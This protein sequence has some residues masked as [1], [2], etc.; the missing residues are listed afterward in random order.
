MDASRLQEKIRRLLALSKSHNPHEA[1]AAAAKAQELMRQQS[2]QL[3]SDVRPETPVENLQFVEK[4]P[5]F[6][7]HEKD[8]WGSSLALIFQRFQPGVRVF[9]VPYKLITKNDP[10]VSYLVV[11]PENLAVTVCELISYVGQLMM[12][13][14]EITFTEY[15]T[16]L[17]FTLHVTPEEFKMQFRLG[18]VEGLRNQVE[19]LQT[20]F[21]QEESTALT[22]ID[23][24]LEQFCKQYDTVNASVQRHALASVEKAGFA[25]GFLAGSRVSLTAQ[26]DEETATL[27]KIYHTL[28]EF[29]EHLPPTQETEEMKNIRKF[30]GI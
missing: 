19:C 13:L 21:T 28:T 3:F 24:K 26:I 4:I 17:G 12:D 9:I 2:A 29:T 20:P 1:A 30:W 8:I 23:D 14:A 10:R 7:Y 18:F 6:F 5:Q 16:T 11:G 15:Q 27:Q 25:Q 22:R